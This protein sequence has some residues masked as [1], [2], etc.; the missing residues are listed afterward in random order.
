MPPGRA[1][2]VSGNDR[3]L[4]NSFE[5][6]L[7]PE[8]NPYAGRWFDFG[9][10]IIRDRTNG[11]EIGDKFLAIAASCHMRFCRFRQWRQTF[12]LHYDFHILTLHDASLRW[13]RWAPL[14]STSPK[15]FRRKSPMFRHEVA[16]TPL[17][18]AYSSSIIMRRLGFCCMAVLPCLLTNLFLD[19]ITQPR[20][21]FLHLRL[22][23]SHHPS[24]D[25]PHLVLLVALDVMKY[26]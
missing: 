19:R 26:K 4:D 16:H 18:C 20:A 13:S 14:H 2:I 12:L 6:K 8:G 11:R 17:N 5:F 9:G 1:L 7:S 24:H 15:P 10:Q 21:R 3:R 22:R 23:I 25:F